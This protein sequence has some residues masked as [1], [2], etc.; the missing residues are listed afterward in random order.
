M[1]QQA[2]AS[3]KSPNQRARR[4]VLMFFIG[5]GQSTPQNRAAG[6]CMETLVLAQF[7]NG[8]LVMVDL[9]H[10]ILRPTLVY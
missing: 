3:A 1:E 4:N 2:I 8:N 9:V 10:L 7:N 5:V 6:M